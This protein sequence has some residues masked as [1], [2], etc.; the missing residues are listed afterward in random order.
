MRDDPLLMFRSMLLELKAECDR[1]DSSLLQLPV[2]LHILIFQ[3][4]F[5]SFSFLFPVTVC[6]RLCTNFYI[7]ETL[8]NLFNFLFFIR[9]FYYIFFPCF[10]MIPVLC[11]IGD[12]LL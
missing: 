11:G 9:L 4:Y 8:N 2:A 12:V 6:N 10:I 7:L 3:K 1:M 5:L